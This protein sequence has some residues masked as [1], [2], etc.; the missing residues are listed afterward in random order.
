MVP[1]ALRAPARMRPRL[2]TAA[3]L[4]ELPSEL[5]S[6]TVRYELDDGRLIVMAPPGDEHGAVE[7]RIAAALLY[8]GTQDPTDQN[9]PKL[10]R[11]GAHIRASLVVG[12]E[13]Q[14]RMAVGDKAVNSG[15]APHKLRQGLDKGT[16]VVAG[17]GV[18]LP[19]GQASITIRTHFVDGAAAAEIAER[20]KARRA[21]V[22]TRTGAEAP[23][24]NVIADVS[25]VMA[26]RDRVRSSDVLQAL[27]ERWQ[28]S[29]AAWSAQHKRSASKCRSSSGSKA[30]T[31]KRGSA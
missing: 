21:A 4:A 29:Y 24:R 6:G 19:A 9:L 2:L 17:D 16:V 12:T 25:T 27:K 28:E 7:L 11:E 23:A 30:Q 10:V 31:S 1:T 18:P 5:P 26:G 22:T 13:E 8:Q 15:A 20:A 14:A 3:D